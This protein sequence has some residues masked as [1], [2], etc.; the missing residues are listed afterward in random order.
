MK[1]VV[2][3]DIQKVRVDDVNE[4]AL[5]EP[6]DAVVRITTAAICGSDL[7]FFHGKAP[8]M[9]GEQLGHEGI[10]VVEEVGDA[11]E[12][13]QAGD[14][15]VISFNVVCGDC[16]FCKHGQTALCEN[17]RNL[18]GGLATGSL[19]GTQAERV[20]VPSA[21]INLLKVPEG[22]DDE[23][24]LFVG[25]ILTTGF[26]G[27]A[28]AGIDQGDTVAVIGAGP[29]GFFAAQAARLHDAAEVL[30]LDMQEDRLQLAE[31]VG[32]IP[33]NVS[34]RNAQMAVAERT[35]G[36]GADVVI[37]AVGSIPAFESALEVVRS[38]GTVCVLGMYTTESV[39]L[40]L[41]LVWMRSL[42]FVMS[43]F[44]PIST[45][46]EDAM[47]AVVDGKIDPLPIISHTLPLVDAPKG[48]EMFDRR[49]ATKVLLKP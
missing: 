25:D 21:D 4:P 19:G 26:Y 7:H 31:K 35:E 40:Q 47:R 5:E 28:L 49:E 43:G 36:R 15:V 8:M 34:E 1:A 24:A 11:V 10:G 37:E 22:M 9:P 30:V 41:G 2:Y 42:K 38:G 39:E 16:W 13:F 3:E 14:R 46:W 29:V 18:G 48:Y 33:I 32:A 27:A 20:L 12:M 45:Y 44:C 23:R 6:S 17:Y